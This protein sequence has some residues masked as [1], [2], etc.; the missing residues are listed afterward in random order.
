MRLPVPLRNRFNNVWFLLELFKLNKLR[1]FKF[2]D[3]YGSELIG[4]FIKPLHIRK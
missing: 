4:I 2:Y 3:I 1:I